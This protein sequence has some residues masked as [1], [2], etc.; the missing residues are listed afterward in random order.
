VV[1]SAI[2]QGIAAHGGLTEPGIARQV[3]AA[4]PAG[5]TLFC[6]SSMPVRDIEW[7]AAARPDAPRVLANRGANGI[8]GVTSSVLGAAAAAAAEDGGPVVGLIGDL[9][10]LHDVSALVWGRHESR[11]AAVLVVIDNGGGGIFD[12]L[13]YP[14]VVEARVFERLFGTPQAV[15]LAA[16]AAGFGIEVHEVTTP[17]GL[18]SSLAEA[19]STKELTLLHCRTERADNV[20]FHQLL[21]DTIVARLGGHFA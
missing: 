17:A 3:F 1:E 4:L 21:T 18:E 9:A 5:A 10:F 2:A 15:D 8:D 11:P 6:S 12:F 19:L 14:G 16:V 7:F 20:A 13:D